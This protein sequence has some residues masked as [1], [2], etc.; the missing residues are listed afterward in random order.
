MDP[1]DLAFDPDLS[2]LTEPLANQLMV[3]KRQLEGAADPLTHT[4]QLRL[5]YTRQNPPLPNAILRAAIFP[6]LPATGDR[7][8]L[9]K[10]PVF[11]VDG[12]SVT[13][14]GKRFDQRDLD[15]LL[16]IFEIGRYEPI[17][18]AF[19]FTTYTLL[20][21]LGREDGADHYRDV[22]ESVSRLLFGMLE[23]TQRIGTR[24]KWFAGS[25]LQSASA[26]SDIN[27]ER[28]ST[29]RIALN[30]KLAVLFGFGMWTRIDL[31][32]R[33]ALGRNQVAKIFHL[34]YSSHTRP[35]VHSYDTLAKL[36]DLQTSEAKQIRRVIR[37]AH[38]ALTSTRFL[39]SYK[40]LKNGIRVTK[41]SERAKKRAP[42]KRKR[43][44]QLPLTQ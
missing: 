32:Q 1:D 33:K 24:K 11:S 37:N 19:T 40:A 16:G 2:H 26:E 35:G 39:A 18:C 34:Y 31:E 8:I 3:L 15:V 28:T 12:L 30:P 10:A 23:I 27:D 29:Y 25:L 14:S 43:A 44:S 42:R 21:Q 13:F 4:E 36:A 38:D 7:P 41:A 22:R 5:P 17:G 20:R 6:A 9:D